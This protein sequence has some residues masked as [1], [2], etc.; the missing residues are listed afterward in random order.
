[1]VGVGVP[2][3]LNF[4]VTTKLTRY[5]GF[6]ANVGIIPQVKVSLYGDATLSYQ[7]YDAYGRLYPFGGSFFLGCGAGYATMKGSFSDTA[8]IP[9]IP[10][11][12]VPAQRATIKS[13]A[14]VKSLIV[15]PQLGFL[16]TYGS[17]FSLG[18]DFGA[19][20]PIAPSQIKFKTQLPEGVPAAYA[21]PASA[22]VRSTLE[23][24]GKQI[25][26]T[27]NFRIAFLL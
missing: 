16:H 25:V 6:G 10:E 9:A 3:L 2:N 26:P 12:M 18:V 17:G 21:D 19:Q 4:G 20:V 1:M 8:D 23:S 5:L 27:I 14:E 13:E 22:K 11:L 7:E 15:T 24:V